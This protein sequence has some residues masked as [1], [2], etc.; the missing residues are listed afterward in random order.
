MKDYYPFNT[1][2]P[3]NFLEQLQNMA[4]THAGTGMFWS[5]DIITISTPSIHTSQH[6]Y[7]TQ[8]IEVDAAPAAE[9]HVSYAFEQSLDAWPT[10]Q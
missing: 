8:I 4:P 1:K 6:H 10:C 9:L 3:K 7:T 2:E 5:N